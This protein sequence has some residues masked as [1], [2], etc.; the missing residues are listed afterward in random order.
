MKAVIS[1]RLLASGKA[2]PGPKPFEIWDRDLRGFILRV[3][4]SGTRSFLVQLGRGRRVTLG[5]L[6][7]LTP[8]Q[9]RELA[10]KVLGNLAHNRPPLAGLDQNEQSS[11]G[12]FVESKYAPWVQANR[13]RTAEY[14]VDRLKRCFGTWYQKGLCEITPELIEEWKIERFRLGRRPTTVLR[15]IATLS[16][17]LSRAVKM[18]KLKDN[19]IRLVDKPRIDRRPQVRYLTAEEEGRL[20]TVLA[21][22]DNEGKTERTSA[23][24]WRRERGKEC[25]PELVHF[26]DH[27][28]PAVILS[29]NTGI[30]RGELLSLKWMDID[31]HQKLLTIHGSSA[32]TGDTRHVPLNSEALQVIEN[33]REQSQ[34]GDR[35]FPIATSFKSAWAGLLKRAR[36]ARFRWHDLRHHFASRLAQAGI[37]L[38]T[39]RELLGHGSLAMT[40]R[41]AHLAPDQKRDAVAKL[42]PRS[43]AAESTISQIV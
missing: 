28:T 31:T 3:Q 17:V 36:I 12:A 8:A 18:G 33:W 32:K 35:V 4:P 6:G 27:L 38:N 30:R 11:L 40:L 19:P 16:S 7:H 25:L 42:L 26:A 37:P 10:E 13:P 14:T 29:I 5:S 34:D 21:E 9:A 24:A 39:V 43:V 20:R 1:A 15:D 23:N 41:Y 22:R 2:N